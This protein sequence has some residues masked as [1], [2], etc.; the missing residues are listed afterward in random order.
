MNIIIKNKSYITNTILFLSWLSLISSI[1]TSL[2][3]VKYFGQ[4]TLQTFN[5]LRIIFPLLVTLIIT[6]I[7]IFLVFKKKFSF[8]KYSSFFYLWSAYFL[9]HII[10]GYVNGNIIGNV[11][12]IYYGDWHYQKHIH[13]PIL[14][15]SSIFLL[16]ISHQQK[17]EFKY[18]LNI[19][20]GIIALISLI[21]LFV[22]L[23]KTETKDFNLYYLID[24]DYN[25]KI[26]DQP[27]PR[28]TGLSRMF[29]IVNL[30]AIS[31]LLFKTFNKYKKIFLFL[32][33]FL[34]SILI[35][36]FQSRG[37]FLCYYLCVL[38]I[39]IFLVNKN[40]KKKINLIIILVFIPILTFTI[41]N[42]KIVKNLT[43][44][45]FESSVI[46][47]EITEP[48]N[49]YLKKT[50]SGRFVLWK[51][52][53]SKYNYK[54]LFGYGPQADRRFLLE[55]KTFEHGGYGNNVSNGFI[56]AFICGGY[57]ALICYL[58]INF[59]ITSNIIKNISVINKL[60]ETDNIF[61]YKLSLIYLLF[62]LIRQLF[63]NSFSL[64][65]ID[66]LIV[67]ICSLIIDKNNQNI[68]KVNI[69]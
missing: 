35:I 2:E 52:S 48:E 12:N 33:I 46:E 34:I 32:I 40:F 1:N 67:I 66:F 21:L 50:D 43:I 9:I 64:F 53:L 25:K 13:L 37:T 8:F 17:I 44:L 62:F 23:I 69:S 29:S 10:S 31:F 28:I 36:S 47:P 65:S 45:E 7:I 24:P 54:N 56:Y 41:L 5:A 16:Y 68:K 20:I 38:Y 11:G 55:D 51:K 27:T 61:Y 58:I 42:S 22:F 57:L 14:G 63:E 39:I 30:F 3:E 15:I 60:K 6:I 49:R 19:L 4:N 18:F 26:I 59:K